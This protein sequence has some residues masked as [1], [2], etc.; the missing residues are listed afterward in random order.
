MINYIQKKKKEREKV[1]KFYYIILI[2]FWH[3]NFQVAL[4]YFNYQSLGDNSG[5]II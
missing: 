5:F 1:R 3:Y 2:I 4:L